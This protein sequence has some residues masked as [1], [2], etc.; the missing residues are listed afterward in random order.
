MRIGEMA[1]TLGLAVLQGDYEDAEIAGGYTSD[2]LS[3][4]MAHA[5]SGSVLIT[6]QAHRNT[7]AVASLVGIRAIVLC[8]GRSVEPEMLEAARSEGL[9][10]FGTRE[11][12]F[13]LSGKLWEALRHPAPA[14]AGRT[15]A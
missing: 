15:G 6:I 8:N 5:V 2:L 4:V 7:V 1:G 10:M 11:S 9:A 14:A 3:D 12:Q 13:E